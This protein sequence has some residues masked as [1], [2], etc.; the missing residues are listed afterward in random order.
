[1]TVTFFG[2]RFV[3]SIQPHRAEQKIAAMGLVN[4]FDYA[5]ANILY[6]PPN[7]VLTSNTAGS[8]RIYLRWSE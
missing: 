2:I 5:N 6:R 4:D 1:M 3:V 7:I 8:K